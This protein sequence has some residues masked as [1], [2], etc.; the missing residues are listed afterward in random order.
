MFTGV[1]EVRKVLI[2]DDQYALQCG[3]DSGVDVQWFYQQQENDNPI[4][5]ADLADTSYISSPPNLYLTYIKAEHEGFYTCNQVS[6][7]YHL[8]VV[9]K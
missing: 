6:T 8:V 1:T 3:D 7:V 5:I 4:A 2:N 9:G